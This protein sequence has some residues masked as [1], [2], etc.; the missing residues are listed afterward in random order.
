MDRQLDVPCMLQ[1]AHT[2]CLPFQSAHK[3]SQS[4]LMSRYAVE[5]LFW[6]L[7]PKLRSVTYHL[8]RFFHPLPRP[9]SIRV[10]C[11][12]PNLRLAYDPTPSSAAMPCT[13]WPG[14]YDFSFCRVVDWSLRDCSMTVPIC[15]ISAS[16]SLWVRAAC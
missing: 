8:L 11:R 14:R 5:R 7:F 10:Y 4:F 3:L 1:T 15:S 12:S 9:F 2:S 16:I 13:S 6:D